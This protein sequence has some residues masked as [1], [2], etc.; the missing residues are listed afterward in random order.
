MWEEAAGGGG[1]RQEAGGSCESR[2]AERIHWWTER[3]LKLFFWNG[4]NGCSGR[5]TYNFWMYLSIH[6]SVYLCIC[7]SASLKTKQFCETSSIFEVGNIKNEAILRGFLQFSR[8]TTSKT[9]QFCETS[10]KMGAEL[11]ASCQCVLRFFPLRL[12]KVLRLGSPAPDF[13]NRY[14]V[15]CFR[16][17][18]RSRFFNCQRGCRRLSLLTGATEGQSRGRGNGLYCV[19]LVRRFVWEVVACS[20]VAL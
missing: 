2:S 3:W 13:W 9:K 15:V 5:L 17:R 19:V 16:G 18:V 10:S 7:P 8:L 20:A 6:Q 12:C 14:S 11:T 1:R 4:C